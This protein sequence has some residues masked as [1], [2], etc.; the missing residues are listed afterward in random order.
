MEN[1]LFSIFFVSTAGS[2]L[3]ATGHLL[4]KHFRRLPDFHPQRALAP[5]LAVGFFLAA[6]AVAPA[7]SNVKPPESVSPTALLKEERALPAVYAQWISGP[8]SYLITSRE[9]AAFLRLTSNIGR[10]QFIQQFWAQRNP[11]PSLPVNGFKEEF[12]RRVDFANRHFASSVP[13]WKTDRGYIYIAY[14]PPDEIAVNRKPEP[15]A[16]AVQTW[17][18]QEFKANGNQGSITFV[19]RTG[20]GDFRIM[21]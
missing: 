7:A 5:V 20:D 10:D 4:L 16:L 19:D 1:K 3:G 21:P 2:A 9:R 15:G 12:Y 18:Y 13:G 17:T 11:D 14:G 8:V 6:A